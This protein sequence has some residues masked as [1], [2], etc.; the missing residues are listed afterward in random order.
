MFIHELCGSWM[1]HPFWK[2]RFVVDSDQDL[3]SLRA[4]AVTEVWIDTDRGA[5]VDAETPFVDPEESRR[6]A[7]DVLIGNGE[8]TRAPVVP[9]SFE[10][11]LERARKVVRRAHGEVLRMF[12]DVRMGAAVDLDQA[13][14]LVESIQQSVERNAGALLSLVRLKDKNAYTY[15]HSISVAALMSALAGRLGLDDDGRRRAGIAG[16]LHDIGKIGIA[17]EILDKPGKLS[18]E[19][20]AIVRDHPRIGHDYLQR[21]ESIDP[22]A[23]DVCLHHHERS[24]G[25]GYPDRLA[26]EEI[27]LFARM[28]AICD[29][30][31]AITSDRPYK[32][33]WD[34]GEAIRKMA[35]WQRG[36]FDETIFRA[37]VKTVGIYPVGTLVRLESGL[38]GVVAELRQGDLLQPLVRVFYNQKRGE[39]VKVERVDL[40][41]RDDLIA[42]V[43]RTEA[44]PHKMADLAR[45]LQTRVE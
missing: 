21:A 6:L 9:E 8:P 33:G 17:S 1:D 24:D 42:G 36:H 18:D 20:F 39:P 32:A 10:R 26:G 31:D 38:I 16:L 22:V 25:R 40:A 13:A 27:T 15:M 3:A 45:E 2:S 12:N 37:F 44:L 4:S 11:E 35:E 7:T 14:E 29:V 23:L 5:D 43:E 41:R 28:G 19:E 34:P 30:Y